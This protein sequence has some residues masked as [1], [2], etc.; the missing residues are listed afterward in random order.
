[1]TFMGAQ[2]TAGG[3]LLDVE[4]VYWNSDAL[5][6]SLVI[7]NIGTSDAKIA[8]LYVGNTASNEIEVTTSTDLGT[9]KL[10]PVGETVLV[11]LDWPNDLAT[12]WTAGKT[13]YFK[14]A[15]TAGTPK[16]FTWKAPS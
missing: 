12:S 15:P 4:N 9:G 5:T 11:V 6:T 2:T 10:L 13:Y 8:R 1:M 14:V 3:T 16:E 7:K